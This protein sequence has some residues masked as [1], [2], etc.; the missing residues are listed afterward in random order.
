[1][2]SFSLL[3]IILG[4]TLST[5]AQTSLVRGDNL[6]EVKLEDAFARVVPGSI[7]IVGENHG[8]K[9]HQAQQ[10]QV[11][12]VLRARGLKVA[13]GME[14]F[15]YPNQGELDAFRAGQL[16]EIDFLKAVNWGSLSFDYY[17]DQSQFPLT[18]ERAQ[19][20]ALNAPGV[21]T[22][23]I[24]KLGIDALSSEDLALLPPHF[25]LGNDLYKE[26]FMEVMGQHLPD[27]NMAVNYFAAQSV[28]DDTMAWKAVDY[29]QNHPDQVM[30]I[31]VGEFHTQYGGG[32]PD[33]IKARGNFPVWTISQV[34]STGLTETE[35]MAEILPSLKFGA[36][37]DFIW[38]GPAQ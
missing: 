15:A 9:S 4:F 35:V 22:R 11:M 1:M 17:R 18:S 24:S 10:L 38:H 20:I 26:R 6:E 12:Q 16:S 3:V 30:V 14:F 7:V 37:A 13:V 33:R 29:L 36:R 5:K 34:N 28:W 25:A 23:K 27:P 19:T 32:L 31:V 2:K 8:F 21:L